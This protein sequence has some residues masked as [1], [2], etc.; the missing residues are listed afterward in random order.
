MTYPGGS[1]YVPQRVVTPDE[2]ERVVEAL[3]LHFAADHLGM[4]SLEQ[5]L[6]LVYDAHTLEQLQQ[7]LVDLPQL[8]RD[9]VDSGMASVVPSNMVPERSVVLAVMG[10]VVR[11]GSWIVPRN[12]KIF[13][14]MGGAEIDLRDAK[15]SPGVTEIEANTIMGGI[16]ITVP[17]GVRVES[18]GA[19]FM[20]GFEASAGD[21][22]ALDPNAPVLRVS[23]LAIMGGVEVKVRKPGRKM[24]ARFQAAL[25]AAGL[26]GELED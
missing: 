20:G 15:F 17:P 14:M 7:T 13:A 2:R 3:C 18:L 26:L 24:L 8:K 12:L 23:G 1:S 11:K 9:K 25:H 16:E 22:T 5:R 10:G 4:E 21:A 6:K 19:A